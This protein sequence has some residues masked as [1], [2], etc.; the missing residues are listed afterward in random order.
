MS[1]NF[2]A[3]ICKRLCETITCTLSKKA[4]ATWLSGVT[5]KRLAQGIPLTWLQ[6]GNPDKTI[7]KSNCE[8]LCD[9]TVT[10]TLRADAAANNLEN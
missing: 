9:K 6:S 4:G 2:S 8:R 10:C 1:Q 7:C 5:C 3:L